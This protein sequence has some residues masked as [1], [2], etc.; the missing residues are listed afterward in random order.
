MR[1]S[2]Q[3]VVTAA[4]E[5]C[6]LHSEG[7]L[8]QAALPQTPAPV[9][10]CG[11]DT[12]N[13]ESAEINFIAR[14]CMFGLAKGGCSMRRAESWTLDLACNTSQAGAPPSLWPPECS[15]AL[16]TRCSLPRLTFGPRP[17][18]RARL[19]PLVFPR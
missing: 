15:G 12:R 3:G 2:W 13:S 16:I 14:G 9:A 1:S 11:T 7:T 4:A 6:S 18:Q 5:L 10:H 17:A 8:P 19:K